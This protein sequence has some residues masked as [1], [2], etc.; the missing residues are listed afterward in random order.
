LR[1]TSEKTITY[2][3]NI[4]E[5]KKTMHPPR[6]EPLQNAVLDLNNTLQIYNNRN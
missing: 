1:E 2:I 3:D 5:G 6:L 4:N